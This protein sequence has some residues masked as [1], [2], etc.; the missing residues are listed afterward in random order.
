LVSEILRN[1]EVSQRRGFR[2]DSRIIIIII[3]I[4]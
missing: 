1:L 2:A 3:I 4:I